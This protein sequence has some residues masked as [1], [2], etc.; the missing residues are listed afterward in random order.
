MFI[1][2]SLKDAIF[3]CQATWCDG[4]RTYVMLRHYHYY[5]IAGQNWVQDFTRRSGDVIHPQLWKSG[6]GYET[7]ED[8]PRIEQWLKKRTDKYASSYI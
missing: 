7:R 5:I 2:A 1:V 3:G 6:S 4:L 8:D